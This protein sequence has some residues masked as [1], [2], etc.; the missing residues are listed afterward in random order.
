MVG[1]DYKMDQVS[2]YLILQEAEWG[3]IVNNLKSIIPNAQKVFLKPSEKSLKLIGKKLK[4]KKIKDIERDA[5]RRVPGF[6]KDFAEAKRKVPR[7]KFVTAGTSRGIA[8]ATAL[9]SSVTGRSVTDVIKKGEMGVRN[10]KVL[11]GPSVVQLVMFG[12]F[13][14]F[15]MSIFVTDGAVVMPAIQ[16]ALHVIGLLVLIIGQVIKALLLIF[17]YLGGK[18]G[19]GG[20]AAGADTPGEDIGS[21]WDAASQPSDIPGDVGIFNP[22]TAMAWIFKYL[23]F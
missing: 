13:V 14:T 8:V 1:W 16:A 15:I 19:V 6:K 20:G 9:V 18:V 12:L 21:F 3:R 23:G 7:L 17:K 2:E 4:G 10:A 11:P 5:I 22:E